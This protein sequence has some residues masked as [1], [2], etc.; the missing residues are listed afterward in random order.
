MY[1]DVPEAATCLEGPAYSAIDGLMALNQRNEEVSDH[2]FAAGVR[3]L[4][5]FLPTNLA[6]QD[7]VA[8]LDLLLRRRDD[9]RQA[10]PNSHATL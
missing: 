3:P 8:Q 10:W 6:L 2:G 5:P 1:Q 9:Q 4:M 7:R